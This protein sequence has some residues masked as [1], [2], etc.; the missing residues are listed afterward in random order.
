[1]LQSRC[2]KQLHDN[3]E[4]AQEDEVGPLRAVGGQLEGD[5]GNEEERKG[6]N[7]GAPNSKEIDA[8][9]RM[10]TFTNPTNGGVS[11][12]GATHAEQGDKD[13]TEAL[14]G[15]DLIEAVIVTC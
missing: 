6:G 2:Q 1:M 15:S 10:R 3:A 14:C 11:A 13:S 9:E 12:R 8:D 4:K 7:K 5:A